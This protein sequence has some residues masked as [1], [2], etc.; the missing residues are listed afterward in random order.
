MVNSFQFISGALLAAPTFFSI[1]LCHAEVTMLDDS[2]LSDLTGQAGLTIDTSTFSPKPDFKY[3]P[4]H[5]MHS[6]LISI[7]GH[8]NDGTLNHQFYTDQLDNMRVNVSVADNSIENPEE[9]HSYGF[10][11]WKEIAQIFV[12]EGNKPSEKEFQS[13]A[14]GIDA[15][16]DHLAVDDKK[17]YEE[18][19]LVIHMDYLD[20]WE[21]DGGFDAYQ[22]GTGLSGNNFK[23]A[24]YQEMEDLVSRSVDFKYSIGQIDIAYGSNLAGAASVQP[25][26][27]LS[28]REQSQTDSS[29]HKSTRMMSNFNM[30]GYLG[31]HDL[32]IKAYEGHD[33]GL[34]HVRET[35]ITWNSYFRV[36]DLDVYIDLKGMQ[37]SDLQ[38][39]NDRGDLSGLNLETHD[40][41]VGNSS[42]GFAH[43][44]RE[45][46]S[47]EDSSTD[48]LKDS[49]KDKLK[50]K[51]NGIQ[52]N[53]RFKGDIDIAHVSFGDTGKSIGSFYIT[54]MYFDTRLKITPR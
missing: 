42:F 22:S 6:N 3:I 52:F 36:T 49:S 40:N 32:H 21:K 45:I 8:G 5:L 48:P 50:Q 30:E 38:I 18:G 23:T 19:G 33:D 25:I 51:K 2:A 20:P 53:T 14:N 44:M 13:L 1:S 7:Q 43:A 35:G 10:S 12:S 39:H 28:S 11:D 24:S 41:S 26:R 29:D 54:D 31:P 37:I 15:S 27:N 46:Y 16:R 4:P 47:Y 9:E 17:Y 34:T